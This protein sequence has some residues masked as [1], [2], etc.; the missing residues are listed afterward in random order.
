MVV[1]LDEL[2]IFAMQGNF[3]KRL[4]RAVQVL[5]VGQNMQKM[6]FLLFKVA[7]PKQQPHQPQRAQMQQAQPAEQV[8]WQKTILS[9]Q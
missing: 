5:E 3:P 4:F 7:M 9:F 6:T 8:N 1:A 2:I